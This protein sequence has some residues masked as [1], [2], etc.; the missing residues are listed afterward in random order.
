MNL[1]N[2][3]A[4]SIETLLQFVKNNIHEDAK[5][6]TKQAKTIHINVPRDVTVHQIFTSLYSENAA[7]EG[8]QPFTLTI[9]PGNLILY[10][11]ESLDCHI[12][13]SAMINQFLVS[14]SSLEDVFLA[15]GE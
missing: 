6:V 8:E 5:I 12:F 4:H 9:M 11:N 7:S 2:D 14:Q 15:L 10:S 1:A 13:L 3:N